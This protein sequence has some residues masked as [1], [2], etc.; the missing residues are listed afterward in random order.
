MNSDEVIAEIE[1][2][3]AIADIDNDGEIEALTMV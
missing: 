1:T 2:A 3:L